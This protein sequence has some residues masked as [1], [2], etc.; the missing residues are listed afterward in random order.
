MRP[1]PKKS[2][3]R[4]PACSSCSEPWRY[5]S[6]RWVGRD[7][8]ACGWP[9]QPLCSACALAPHQRCP[10]TPRSVDHPSCQL[11]APNSKPWCG[12][13]QCRLGRSSL[14]QPMCRPA[15]LP[16]SRQSKF[17][18]LCCLL[19][20]HRPPAHPHIHPPTRPHP[21]AHLTT[22]RCAAGVRRRGG[23]R[24]RDAGGAGGGGARGGWGACSCLHDAGG[25]GAQSPLLT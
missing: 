24:H 21:P 25:G 7:M 23:R 19:I 17:T 8:H 22:C 2:R 6:Y 1:A 9:V 13:R 14:A 4:Y 20:S 3:R 12:G 10:G 16:L 15:P 18:R 5:P 11:S